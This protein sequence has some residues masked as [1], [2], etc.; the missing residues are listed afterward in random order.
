MKK[1]IRPDER[2]Q[3]IETFGTDGAG[4]RRLGLK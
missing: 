2:G 4:K 1:K 3:R